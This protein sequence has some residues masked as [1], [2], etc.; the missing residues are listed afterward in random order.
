MAMSVQSLRLRNLHLGFLFARDLKI[1][2]T[3]YIVS[4]KSKE[5]LPGQVIEIILLEKPA[6]RQYQHYQKIAKRALISSKI[7]LSMFGAK[8]EAERLPQ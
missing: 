1:C 3:D 4:V 5:D 2:H 7:P 8:K 6:D